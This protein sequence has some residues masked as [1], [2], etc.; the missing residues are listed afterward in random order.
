MSPESPKRTEKSGSNQAETKVSRRDV[1]LGF[2]A[3]A[4][5]TGLA[6]AYGEYVDTAAAETAEGMGTNWQPLPTETEDTEEARPESRI[7]GIQ[8][9][10]TEDG[11]AIDGFVDA[12][13]GERVV[14]ENNRNALGYVTRGDRRLWCPWNLG[15]GD[16]IR[17]FAMNVENGTSGLLG[18]WTVRHDGESWTLEEKHRVS[19]SPSETTG[20]TDE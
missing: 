10:E 4:T 18:E 7:E 3:G 1:I 13:S 14:V 19:D 17:A 6:W 8:A 12:A 16:S 5:V 15:F 2:T 20:G 11:V 9:V